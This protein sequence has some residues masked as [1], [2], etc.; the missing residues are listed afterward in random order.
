MLASLQASKCWH[1]TRLLVSSTRLAALKP[2]QK[3]GAWGGQIDCLAELLVAGVTN[4][5]IGER[6]RSVETTKGV[7]QD[8]LPTFELGFA[9]L[10]LVIN[11]CRHG[12]RF[13]DGPA[14]A[15]CPAD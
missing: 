6:W 4:L 11:A 3:Y 10:H 2:A 1:R 12:L 14:R 9:F 13:H 15:K 7:L 5:A 8:V